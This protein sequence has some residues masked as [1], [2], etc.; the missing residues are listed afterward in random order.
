MGGMELPYAIDLGVNGAIKFYRQHD[1]YSFEIGKYNRLCEKDFKEIPEEEIKSSGYVVDTLEAALWCLLNTQG[2]K[3][4]VLKAVNLGEDTDTVAAV[5]GGLAGMYYGYDSIPKNWVSGIVKRNFIESLCDKAQKSF[6]QNS[7][8]KILKYIPL[9]KKI[10]GNKELIQW[11]KE[12]SAYHPIVNNYDL[13]RQIEEFV[14]TFYDSGASVS[15]YSLIIQNGGWN[16]NDADSV[17]KEKLLQADLNLTKAILTWHFR[18]DHFCEGALIRKSIAEGKIL[19][20][21]YRL[22]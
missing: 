2:Y 19:T 9:F 21:L 14:Q 13:D 18:R 12:Y 20:L 16:E 4:C 3:E 10:D 15:D 6:E 7:I 17:S 5:A 1:D 11:C 8:N 22:Q